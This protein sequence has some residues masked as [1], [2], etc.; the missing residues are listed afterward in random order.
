MC[1]EIEIG[2]EVGVAILGEREEEV[3]STDLQVL[4]TSIDMCPVE[5]GEAVRVREVLFDVAA[6]DLAHELGRI[7]GGGDQDLEVEVGVA[8]TIG[9]R[10]VLP[11]EQEAGV[12]VLL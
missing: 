9:R 11:G 1:L 5:A 7:R 4:S 6:A 2:G 8:D 12:E 10:I 3:G